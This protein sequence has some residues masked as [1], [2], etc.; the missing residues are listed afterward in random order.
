MGSPGS[1]GTDLE[2]A[3]IQG[4]GAVV[5]GVLLLALCLLFLL[6]DFLV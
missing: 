3:P 2:K 1:I 5:L 4:L 6:L